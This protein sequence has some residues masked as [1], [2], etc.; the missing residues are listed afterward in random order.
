MINVFHRVRN[1]SEQVHMACNAGCIHRL[2]AGALL[3]SV[4]CIGKRQ[5]D[6]LLFYFYHFNLIEHKTGYYFLLQF[7][8]C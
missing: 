7:S 4:S 1:Y 8:V 3:G 2:R 6:L 5:K